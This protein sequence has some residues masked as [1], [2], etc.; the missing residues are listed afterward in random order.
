MFDSLSNWS[1]ENSIPRYLGSGSYL[2]TNGFH[3]TLC[4]FI[5]FPEI[6]VASSDDNT[7][8]LYLQYIFS[9]TFIEQKRG[10]SDIMTNIPF[11][12]VKEPKKSTISEI[13][14][15]GYVKNSLERNKIKLKLDKLK[16]RYSASLGIIKQHKAIE[17]V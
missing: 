10:W 8:R 4:K 15:M 9:A 2:D 14:G 7:A 13:L 11:Y 12:K 5:G 6:E 16:E 3:N 17:I 1:D